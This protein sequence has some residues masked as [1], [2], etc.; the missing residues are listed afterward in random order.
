MKTWIEVEARFN[1]RPADTSVFAEAFERFGCHSSLESEDPPAIKAYLEGFNG[2]SKMANDLRA[3]LLER[4]AAEVHL[5]EVPD[6]DWSEIWKQHFKPRRIGRRIVVVPSWETF[7]ASEDDVI[8][9]LD[10]GQAFGTGEHPTTRL[11]L[12]LLERFDIAERSVLDIGCGSGILAIAA[13]KLGAT[14]VN[15]IDVDSS[16]VEIS[17]KNARANDVS[18]AVHQEEGFG[19]WSR[20]RMW[21]LIL[22]NIVSATLVRLASEVA[23]HLVPNG[24]WVVSGI[25]QNNWNDV[26]EEATRCGFELIERTDEDDWIAAAFRSAS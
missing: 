16:A 24:L 22:A 26:F 17:R 7:E 4:G 19:N 15:A 9:G 23:G 13:A 8:I 1:E 6:E 3:V 2:S 20:G 10:P 12:E 11:C 5:T 14:I 18:L 21:D 25:L